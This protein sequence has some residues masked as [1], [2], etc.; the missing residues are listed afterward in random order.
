MGLPASLHFFELFLQV[1]P[2]EFCQV[3]AQMTKKSRGPSNSNIMYGPPDSSL[4]LATLS[5]SENLESP[6]RALRIS[7][8]GKSLGQWMAEYMK[9]LPDDLH[10]IIWGKNMILCYAAEI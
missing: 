3:G 4:P 6:L 1:N 10:C 7:H 2:G 8:K 9:S 5:I